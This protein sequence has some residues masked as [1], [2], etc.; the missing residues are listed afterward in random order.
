M[1]SFKDMALYEAEDNYNKNYKDALKNLEAIISY[2]RKMDMNNK[3]INPLLDAV[4]NLHSVD[5][6]IKNALAPEEEKPKEK[7]KTW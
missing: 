3:L 2:G 6:S 7:P 4:K 1:K 5:D